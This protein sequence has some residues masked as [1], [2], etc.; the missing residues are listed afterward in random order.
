[1][2]EASGYQH[3][4]DNEELNKYLKKQQ[5]FGK[6]GLDNSGRIPA[7][8][9]HREMA[10]DIV[11]KNTLKQHNSSNQLITSQLSVGANETS[12]LQASTLK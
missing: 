10:F 9:K 5:F 7:S 1:M 2:T 6:L 8:A 4:E 11:R 12:M 3:E